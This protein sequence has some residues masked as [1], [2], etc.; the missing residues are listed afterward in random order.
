[1]CKIIKG[2]VLI[3]EKDLNYYINHQFTVYSR[4]PNVD[5]I[6]ENIEAGQFRL[7]FS[8]TI[9]EIAPGSFK[10]EWITD[11]MSLNYGKIDYKCRVVVATEKRVYSSC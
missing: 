1:M 9:P 2:K 3:D 4:I 11:K 5:D 8:F 6:E 10:Y 7:P